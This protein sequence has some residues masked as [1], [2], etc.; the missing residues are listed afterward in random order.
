[1]AKQLIA[2]GSDGLVSI[3]AEGADYEN[4]LSNLPD[5]YFNSTFDYIYGVKVFSGTITTTA[6]SSGSSTPVYGDVM[7]NLGFHEQTFVPIVAGYRVSPGDLRGGQFLAGD[8]FIYAA[9]GSGN[10]ASGQGSFLILAVGSDNGSVYLRE[11]Y[12]AKNGS[13]PAIS[14]P[15][16]VYCMGNRAV[17]Q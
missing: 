16:V 10:A 11:T 14:V 6:R 3:H 7:H 15:Y 9:N 5:I 1:M 4:P 2:R 12:Y 8:S 13:I 17:G